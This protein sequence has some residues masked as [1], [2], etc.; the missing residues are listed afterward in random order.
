MAVL[1]FIRFCAINSLVEPLRQA[2]VFVIVRSLR[3]DTVH[4]LLEKLMLL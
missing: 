4:I 2:L 3:V 1:D